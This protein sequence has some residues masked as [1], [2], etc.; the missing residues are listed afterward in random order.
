V[1]PAAGRG[2]GIGH[3]LCWEQHERDGTWWAW[4]SW[5]QVSSARPVH[6]VVSVSAGS[7]A[8]IETPDAYTDVPRRVLKADGSIAALRPA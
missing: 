4:V 1:V 8:P 5:I 3:L 7:L 6:K 2:G